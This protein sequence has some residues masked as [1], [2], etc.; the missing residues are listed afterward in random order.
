MKQSIFIRVYFDDK[1]QGVKQFDGDQIVIG[2]S[3]NSNLHLEDESVSPVHAVIE[4]RDTGYYISDLGSAFGT[5]VNDQKVIDVPIQNGDSVQVGEYILEFFIGIPKPTSPPKVP[6]QETV[7]A[8]AR[9]PLVEAP[10]SKPAIPEQV[11]QHDDVTPVGEVEKMQQEPEPIKVEQEPTTVPKKPDQDVPKGQRTSDQVASASVISMTGKGKGKAAKP[12]AAATAVARAKKKPV[13]Q[14]SRFGKR[15]PGGTFAPPGAF[16]S[17][18]EVIKPGKGT[19]VEVLVAWNQKVIATHHFTE[20][21]TYTIGPNSKADVT[22]PI[23]TTQGSSSPFLMLGSGGVILVLNQNPEGQWTG[24]NGKMSLRDLKKKSR[25]SE[26]KRGTELV[27]QQGEMVRWDL[28]GGLLSVYVRFK[29]DSVKP[30][31]APFLDFTTTEFTGIILAGVISAILGLYMMVYSPVDT[32][33]EALLEVP[34]RRAVVRFNRPKKKVVKVD[35]SAKEKKVVK[36]DMKKSKTKKQ[37]TTTTKKKSGKTAN[38]R[39]TKSKKKSK[40]MVSVVKKGGAKKTGKK[41]GSSAK[42]RKK[43]VSKMGILSAFGNKGMNETLSK[44]YTGAG[45]LS[46]VANQATGAAGFSKSRPGKGLGSRFKNVGAGG[47][48]VATEGISSA[49]TKGR[50]TGTTGT[51]TGGLG[52]KGRVDINLGGQEAEV[53]GTIDREAIRRVILKNKRQIKACYDRAL[54]RNRDLYGKLVIEWHIEEKGVVTKARVKSNSLGSKSVGNCI[55]R[56]LRTWRFPEP[57]KDQVAQVAY[58]FVFQTQ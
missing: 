7:E 53:T 49:G 9:P 48:G 37:A 52:K 26:T 45:G 30:V 3:E 43:D 57:P 20:P 21:S 13:Q 34:L 4:E 40:K 41:A 47:T 56:R 2:T 51:G 14:G 50:G 27:L 29:P 12:S 35:A 25:L 23:R 8:G 42:S 28:E 19:V 24:E 33:D 54:N 55:V 39:K 22:I 17:L 44:S 16:K 46:G 11:T 58:P 18:D 15:K 38:L 6:G 32:D 31:V 36:V 5:L 1:L 10:D